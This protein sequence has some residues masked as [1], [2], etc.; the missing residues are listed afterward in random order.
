LPFY[1][2]HGFSF[3]PFKIEDLRAGAEPEAVD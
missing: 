3:P 2:N 1:G